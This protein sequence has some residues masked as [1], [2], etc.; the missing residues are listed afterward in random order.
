ME[1]INL[2]PR[3]IGISSLAASEMLADDLKDFED[4]FGRRIS[5]DPS[6]GKDITVSQEFDNTSGEMR[7][8]GKIVVMDSISKEILDRQK[9]A[10]MCDSRQT[11]KSMEAIETKFTSQ[12]IG[13]AKANQKRARAAGRR[14]AKRQRAQRNKERKINSA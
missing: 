13:Q 12:Q 6:D 11:N 14:L 4:R 3:S 8:T 1:E 10:A 7:P 2:K 9:S 5:I